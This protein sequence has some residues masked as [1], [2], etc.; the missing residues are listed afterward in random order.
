MDESPLIMAG[1]PWYR[2]DL[3]SSGSIIAKGFLFLLVAALATTL[4]FLWP[5]KGWGFAVFYAVSVWAFCRF[6]YFAF[7]VITNYV[8]PGYK[9]AGLAD[10]VMRWFRRPR[11]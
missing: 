7:Y 8:D 11:R 2:R 10:F 3:K 4:A 9:Y 6:Y 1:L 5:G